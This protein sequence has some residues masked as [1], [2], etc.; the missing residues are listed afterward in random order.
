MLH[1]IA[2]VTWLRVVSSGGTLT[3]EHM[4]A[5]SVPVRIHPCNYTDTCIAK[6]GFVAVVVHVILS[7]YVWQKQ[8]TRGHGSGLRCL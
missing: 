2:L 4:F 1:K 7:T 8:R 3:N 5:A 6:E